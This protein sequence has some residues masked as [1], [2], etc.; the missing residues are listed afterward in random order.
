MKAQKQEKQRTY[1]EFLDKQAMNHAERELIN[2][3]TREEKKINF[4]D[5]QAYKG[6]D[7]KLFSLVPGFINS[8]YAHPLGGADHLRSPGKTVTEGNNDMYA[9]GRPTN[10]ES[11]PLQNSPT[12]AQ[13]QVQA[14]AQ[15]QPQVQ[16]TQ[17]NTLNRN[18]YSNNP[19]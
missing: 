11:S 10:Y 19:N 12:I 17:S 8:K 15:P 5:L 9:S 4:G 2:K 3:M 7:S 16:A 18:L 14:Q 6:T 13:P 1:K